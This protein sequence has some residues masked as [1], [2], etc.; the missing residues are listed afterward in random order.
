MD[1]KFQ[2]M[3]E[4]ASDLA[5]EQEFEEAI[6][7]YDKI[8]KKE[9]KNIPALLD[10]A[11]TLQRMGK[12]SQSFQLYEYVLNQ[13]TKNLDALIGKASKFLVSWFKTYS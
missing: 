9:P 10:K 2:K 8:L 7:L 6:L 13:D 11:V 5:E 3:L 4:Q 12:N 1:N